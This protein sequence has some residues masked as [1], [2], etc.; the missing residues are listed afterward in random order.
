MC[1]FVQACPG[2]IK[3]ADLLTLIGLDPVLNGSQLHHNIL[4][5]LEVEQSPV[6]TD[7]VSIVVHSLC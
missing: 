7:T 4:L 6:D 3:I 2:S 1:S 5:C